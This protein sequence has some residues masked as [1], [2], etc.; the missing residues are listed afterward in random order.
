MLKE[1]CPLVE[2]SLFTQFAEHVFFISGAGFASPPPYKPISS[3]LALDRSPVRLPFLPPGLFP[4]RPPEVPKVFLL[5]CGGPRTVGTWGGSPVPPP[6]RKGMSNKRPSPERWQEA[7]VSLFS[8]SLPPP[9]PG[10]FPLFSRNPLFPVVEDAGLL[11][12]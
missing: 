9:G 5:R 4:V 3:L 1:E 6:E 2:F 8:P 10:P 12:V 11:A 7:P